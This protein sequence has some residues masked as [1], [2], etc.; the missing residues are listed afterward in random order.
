MRGRAVEGGGVPEG[1]VCGEGGGEGCVRGG[2]LFGEGVAWDGE[3]WGVL[4]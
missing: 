2:V 1:G 4:V 3:A